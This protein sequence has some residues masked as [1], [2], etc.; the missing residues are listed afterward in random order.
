MKIPCKRIASAFLLVGWACPNAYAAAQHLR[1][2]GNHGIYRLDKGRGCAADDMAEGV[3][4]RVAVGPAGLY[5]S[6]PLTPKVTKGT[7]VTL[8]VDG[9]SKPIPLTGAEQTRAWI[10]DDE[11]GALTDLLKKGNKEISVKLPDGTVF[12]YELINT[13]MQ[14][15]MDALYSCVNDKNWK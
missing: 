7:T 14:Q 11:K 8:T 15:I 1:D 13:H 9:K 12:G 10:A 3:L 6:F 5:F 4:V 2:V